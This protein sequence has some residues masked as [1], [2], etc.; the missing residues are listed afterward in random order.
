MLRL[1]TVVSESIALLLDA[2]EASLSEVEESIEHVLEEFGEEELKELYPDV[3]DMLRTWLAI[4]SSPEL[5][6]KL[7][8][9]RRRASWA[10]GITRLRRA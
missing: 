7:R 8:G 6:L 9:S 4:L 10:E 2:G 1:E 3:K 5:E